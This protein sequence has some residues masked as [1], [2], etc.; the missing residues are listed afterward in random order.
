MW[1]NDFRKSIYKY[2]VESKLLGL[3]GREEM[4]N[5][6]QK[7][8]TKIT[9]EKNTLSSLYVVEFIMLTK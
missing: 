9:N 2:A 1:N 5:E 3:I 8:V 7:T 6:I 4:E